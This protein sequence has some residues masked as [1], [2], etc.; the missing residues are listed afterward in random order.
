MFHHFFKW[1]CWIY[2]IHFFCKV[3][4]TLA[5]FGVDSCDQDCIV[6]ATD[7]SLFYL[8]CHKK[9]AASFAK[10]LGFLIEKG[11]RRSRQ[12]LLFLRGS[13]GFLQC[14]AMA[15]QGNAALRSAAD[16]GQKGLVLRLLAAWC[17]GGCQKRRRPDFF[18]LFL[19]NLI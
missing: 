13:I 17:C 9:W 2:C 7:P 14:L 16:K 1:I 15:L 10:S 12:Y 8:I 3:C 11:H 19:R 4:P 6:V 18:E 5:T